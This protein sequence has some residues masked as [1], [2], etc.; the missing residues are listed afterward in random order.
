MVAPLLLAVH[1]GSNDA[2]AANRIRMWL[3]KGMIVFLSAANGMTPSGRNVANAEQLKS[4]PEGVTADGTMLF[5]LVDTS[6]DA[7]ELEHH[8][9][10]RF[11]VLAGEGVATDAVTLYLPDHAVTGGQ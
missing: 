3:S 9:Q 10:L 6:I 7:Q 4:I 8:P 2:G 5:F 1:A 11:A